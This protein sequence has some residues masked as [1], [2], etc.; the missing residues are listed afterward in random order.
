[1]KLVTNYYGEGILYDDAIDI[2]IQPAYDKALAELEIE[3]FS[4]P[5]MQIEEIGSD[6][7][8]TF[9]C[10]FAIKPEV[11]LGDYKGVVAYK[12]DAIVDED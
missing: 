1:M 5:D 8:M 4:Q 11:K 12:P 7:G 10:T 3:P 9:N 2:A 6:K